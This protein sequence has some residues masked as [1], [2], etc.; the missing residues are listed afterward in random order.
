MFEAWPKI[1]RHNGNTI[2]ISEKIDGTNAAILIEQ[3]KMVECQSRTRIIDRHNDNF[4]FANWAWDNQERI[5][6]LLGEGRHFGEWA[7][8]GIQKNPLNLL[9]KTFFLFDTHRWHQKLNIHEN[10]GN[11]KSV[12]ELYVGEFSP[13]IITYVMHKLNLKTYCHQ[14]KSMESEGIIIYY[15]SSRS[16]EKLTFKHVNG[17]WKKEDV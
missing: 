12:P 1:P 11:I 10:H 13:G 4:G 3:G 15:H 8:P 17:K 5:E 9:E 7:G 6:N 14:N 2:T 16:Y